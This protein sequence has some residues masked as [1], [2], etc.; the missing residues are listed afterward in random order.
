M[1]KGYPEKVEVPNES[2]ETYFQD[3]AEL[4]GIYRTNKKEFDER[5]KH[6]LESIKSLENIISAEV[7]KLGKTVTVGNIRAEYKQT[8]VIR[9]KKDQENEQ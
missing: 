6:L 1:P 4:K 2:L 5:N 3:L 7:L 8:V 9:M